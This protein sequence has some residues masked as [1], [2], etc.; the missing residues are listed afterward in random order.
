[1]QYLNATPNQRI[2]FLTKCVVF[3]V[4]ELSCQFLNST[5]HQGREVWSEGEFKNWKILLK[6]KWHFL[7]LE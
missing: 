7:I 1:M 6:K 2:T 5:L 4:T 3:V